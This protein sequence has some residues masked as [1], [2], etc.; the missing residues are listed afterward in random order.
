MSSPPADKIMQ[1]RREGAFQPSLEAMAQK[2]ACFWITDYSFLKI[3]I[4]RERV[5]TSLQAAK[6]RSSSMKETVAVAYLFQEDWDCGM[7]TQTGGE[8]VHK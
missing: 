3:H 8:D 5:F 1:V 6:H 4:F 7:M 2:R